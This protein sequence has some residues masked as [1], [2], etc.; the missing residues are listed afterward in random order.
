LPVRYVLFSLVAL[1]AAALPA[2]ADDV[3]L[4]LDPAL[5]TVHFTLG[6]FLHTVHGTFR[7]KSG[8][9]R[10]DPAAGKAEGKI[11]VDLTTGSTGNG[12]RDGVMRERVLEVGR[13]PDA[14][15]TVDSVT[16]TF[17][18]KATSTL[19]LRGLLTIHG[20]AHPFTFQT[21]VQPK[22]GQLE[23]VSHSSVPYVQWGMKNP[24]TF[25]LHVGDRVDVDVHAIA[26]IR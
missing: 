8:S 6:A 11:D 7:I 26:R 2:R 21:T 25:L 19:D 22:G 23:A 13:F 5:S 18:P 3:V 16:G 12:E 1:L 14:V 20:D 10:F 4:E 17:N 24:S 9:V 15:F